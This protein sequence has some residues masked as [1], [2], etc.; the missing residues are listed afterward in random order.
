MAGIQV[1][2]DISSNV[3]MFQSLGRDAFGSV[4][5]ASNKPASEA[6]GFMYSRCSGAGVKR[7]LFA[8]LRSAKASLFH[9]ASVNARYTC[10]SLAQRVT[11]LCAAEGNALWHRGAL[12]EQPF[13]APPAPS[14]Y[15]CTSREAVV[16]KMR[17]CL[18]SWRCSFCFFF[19]H[20]GVIN[21]ID[22]RLISLTFLLNCR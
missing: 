5:N 14:R 3:Q 6:Q 22:Q 1:T 15:H 19:L 2:T 10:L 20:I 9:G 17:I 8:Y 13:N 11:P 21:L 18:R 7:Q 16:E 4:R 12:S